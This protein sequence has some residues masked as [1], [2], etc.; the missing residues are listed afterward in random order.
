M[1]KPKTYSQFKDVKIINSEDLFI[2]KET[3]KAKEVIWSRNKESVIIICE[4][5]CWKMSL[6]EYSKFEKCMNILKKLENQNKPIV[7]EEV[8]PL[9]M[10]GKK[11]MLKNFVIGSRDAG[12]VIGSLVKAKEANP[13]AKAVKEVKEVIAIAAV[14]EKKDPKTGKVIQK[15]VKAVKGVKGVKASPAIPAQPATPEVRTVILKC[16]T[17]GVAQEVIARMADQGYE[18]EVEVKHFEA[19]T[20]DLTYKAESDKLI[21]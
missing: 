1:K 5:S 15:K 21:R 11:T 16:R 19:G 18:I 8:K 2:G 10:E 3:W 14:P 12:L 7:I 20:F 17:E 4:D 6:S 13:A 9:K